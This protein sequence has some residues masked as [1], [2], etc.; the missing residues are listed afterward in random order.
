VTLKPVLPIHDAV[1]AHEPTFE[2]PAR[3]VVLPRSISK[4]VASPYYSFQLL[5]VVSIMHSEN[6][7]HIEPHSCGSTV[8]LRIGSEIRFQSKVQGSPFG[9]PASLADG[10]EVPL[11]LDHSISY[12]RFLPAGPSSQPARTGEYAHTCSPDITALPARFGAPTP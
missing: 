4:K 1:Q 10:C 9:Y 6:L 12:E 8:I 11:P 3:C 5:S 7:P 2:Y